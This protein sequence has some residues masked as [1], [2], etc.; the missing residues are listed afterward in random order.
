MK[1]VRRLRDRTW[2][3]P[4]AEGVREAAGTQLV[5]TYIGRRQATVAKWVALLPIFEVCTRETGYK[6]GGRMMETWWRQ[7]A[8]EKQLRATLADS[9]EAKRRRSGGENVTQ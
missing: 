3:T 4:G 7:E 9:R 6:W 5:R 8:A 2:E 1:R